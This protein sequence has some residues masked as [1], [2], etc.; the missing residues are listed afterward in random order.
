MPFRPRL[1]TLAALFVLATSRLA[2][3]AE[4]DFVEKRGLVG[5]VGL[6]LG[7]AGVSCIPKCSADRQS[8]AVVLLR[9]GG[10]LSSQLAVVLEADLYR[11]DFNTPDGPARWSMS[12]YMIGGVW[13]PN[14]DET[15]FI[16]VGLGLAV[17]RIDV[18]FPTV[19]Y[20]PLNSSDLG[21]TIGIG[22]DFRFRENMAVTAFATYLVSGRSQ[23]LIGRAD[24]GAKLSMDLIHAGLAFSIF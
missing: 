20:Q 3:Q 23:A 18:E 17:G 13:Y 21:G 12:W 5:T 14:A 9:G 16:N 19:G 10:K 1:V 6:G 7:T 24:S 8:G 11:R 4:F 22:K 15:F 2:A